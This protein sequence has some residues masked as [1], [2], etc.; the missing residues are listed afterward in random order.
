M[1][2]NVVYGGRVFSRKEFAEMLGISQTTA[3]KYLEEYNGKAEKIVEMLSSK[4]IYIYKGKQYTSIFELSQATGIDRR[5]LT[6]IL[7]DMPNK[8]GNIINVDELV[9]NYYGT[10]ITYTYKGIEYKTI[11]EAAKAVRMNHS[12]LAKYLKLANN[13]ME[14]AMGLF[15]E[16]H[17]YYTDNGIR[18]A[19][20]KD[21]ADALGVT[22]KTLLKYIKE[23]GS[24]EKAVMAIRAR[25]SE[26]Y[27]WNDTKYDSFASLANAIGIPTITLK[28][29]LEKEADG[30]IDKAY[31]IYQERNAGKYYGYVY[32]GIEY[33]SIKEVLKAYGL[34][35]QRYYKK[36]K[37]NNGDFKKTIDEL[38]QEKEERE[39]KKRQRDKEENE[40]EIAKERRKSER[41]QIQ[42]IFGGVIYHTKADVSKASGISE[43]TV[44]RLIE[45]YGNNLDIALEGREEPITYTY[46]GKTFNSIKA[47]A[48]YTGKRELRLGRYIRKYNRDAEKAIFMMNLR[49]NRIQKKTTIA[50]SKMSLQ[51]TAIILGIK[52]S[53][54]VTCMNSGMTI[55]EIK[56]N[57]TSKTKNNLNKRSATIMYDNSMSLNQYCIENGLNYSCIYYAIT[58]YGKTPQ[59]AIENYKK[60]GQKVPKAWIFE[61]YGV[62]L[63]HLLLSE[64]VSSTKVVAIMRKDG[65][66]LNEAIEHCIIRDYSRERDLDTAWQQEIYYFLTMDNFSKEEREVFIKEF[67]VTEE[68]LDCVEAIK[69]K[70]NVIERK[71]LLFEFAECIKN[72]VFPQEELV[73]LM[74]LYDI[75]N[76][77]IDTIY[78]E[79]YTRFKSGVLLAE[80]EP[81]AIKT[82][83][84]NEYIRNWGEMV[85]EQK[86][87][88]K[89]EMP[90][91]YEYIVKMFDEIC[92]YKNLLS[93]IRNDKAVE[94][95][96]RASVHTN[97]VTN[98]EVR[99]DLEIELTQLLDIT[100]VKE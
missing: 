42:Y 97:V 9:E 80:Q 90:E 18:Y 84:V 50:D 49:D 75:T 82:N 23:K 45:K 32:D 99:K 21:L 70:V 43:T 51:D 33:D 64:N 35:A 10:K 11:K 34:T 88:V 73:E 52:Y 47:L 89:Q 7:N 66:T 46:D 58:E 63:K 4:M 2:K 41:A 94:S 85:D 5:A 69:S 30:D 67:Y 56:E 20:Q 36:I 38:I 22:Q 72:K 59:E 71:K 100:A 96:M 6:R 39:E 81:E 86:A 16:E 8:E 61:R 12:T 62:L 26:E 14:K 53:E 74:N 79:L 68:E 65:V 77:E 91:E 55:D 87:A 83:K 24:I 54:L 28:R 31:E 13:D 40:K 3:K 92:S 1:R 78:L 44:S 60:N 37:E 95:R 27:E 57:I 76:D 25:V 48:K 29:I 19:S 98:M 17:T 93:E 15:Y